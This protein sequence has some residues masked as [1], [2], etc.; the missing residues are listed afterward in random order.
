MSFFSDLYLIYDVAHS[1]TWL[2]GRL[3]PNFMLQA[4][5]EQSPYKALRHLTVIFILLISCSIIVKNSADS[6]MDVS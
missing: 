1:G 4:E 3:R 5:D 6:N 2:R